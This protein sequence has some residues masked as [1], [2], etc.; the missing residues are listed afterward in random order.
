MNSF[1][2]L[3]VTQPDFISVCVG[4]GGGAFMYFFTKIARHFH[5]RNL[6]K[7]ILQRRGARN[8]AQ[9]PKN[10]KVLSQIVR[11]CYAP[12]HAIRWNARYTVR[13]LLIT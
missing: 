10:R 9:I 11:A 8:T 13:I 2:L 12:N 1:L 4:G 6:F 7:V 5:V 3:A